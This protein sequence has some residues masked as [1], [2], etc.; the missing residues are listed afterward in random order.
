MC[1]TRCI[2]LLN[3]NGSGLIL[4][5]FSR[6]LLRLQ[7]TSSMLL[8][9]RCCRCLLHPRVVSDNKVELLQLAAVFLGR[10]EPCMRS[11]LLHGMFLFLSIF[12]LMRETKRAVLPPA[13]GRIMT[14]PASP[15]WF[16][17]LSWP[18]PRHLAKTKKFLF[19]PN[20][21]FA[22]YPNFFF[23][24]PPHQ[25]IP[26]GRIRGGTATHKVDQAKTGAPTRP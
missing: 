13:L 15:L 4:R 2:L 16:W 5:C 9:L 17:P 20:V 14:V 7:V 11:R 10:R 26:F 21:L 3:V 6:R 18:G 25:S 12:R 19:S 23:S 24:W 22:A 1:C 8:R